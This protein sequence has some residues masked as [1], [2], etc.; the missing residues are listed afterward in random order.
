MLSYL[1]T[2]ATQ[3]FESFGSDILVRNLAQESSKPVKVGFTKGTV[4][5]T[6]DIMADDFL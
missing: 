2:L 6:F 4:T 3:L 5:D 1:S